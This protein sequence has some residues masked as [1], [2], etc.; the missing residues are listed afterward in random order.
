MRLLFAHTPRP[1]T[2]SNAAT[3]RMANISIASKQSQPL[4]HMTM[5]VR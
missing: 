4:F 5:K 3:I 1:N 2:I